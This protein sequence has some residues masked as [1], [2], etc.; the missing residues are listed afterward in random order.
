LVGRSRRER[1]PLGRIPGLGPTDLSA[2]GPYQVPQAKGADGHGPP[3]GMVGI[4][5]AVPL[6]RGPI[7]WWEMLDRVTRKG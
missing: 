4:G 2:I 7:V 1:R 6:R 5:P 3:N